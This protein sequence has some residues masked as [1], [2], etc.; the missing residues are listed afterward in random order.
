[1]T[2]KGLI[3]L[4]LKKVSYLKAEIENI[5]RDLNVIEIVS[6]KNLA[7]IAYLKSKTKHRIK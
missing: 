1:M 7:D 2:D 5:T 4:L 3:K 6:G